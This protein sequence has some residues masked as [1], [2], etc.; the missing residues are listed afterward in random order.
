MYNLCCA[1]T[2]NFINFNFFCPGTLVLRSIQKLAK[3]GMRAPLC[4]ITYFVSINY[5][6]QEPFIS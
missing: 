3:Y 1:G 4:K 5:V 6:V 2:F